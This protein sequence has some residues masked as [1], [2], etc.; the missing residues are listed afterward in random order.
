MLSRADARAGARILGAAC[1]NRW[2]FFQNKRK[3]HRDLKWDYIEV[4]KAKRESRKLDR[5]GISHTLRICNGRFGGGSYA[6][7]RLVVPLEFSL[8]EVRTPATMRKQ[9]KV[10]QRSLFNQRKRDLL[11]RAKG[12]RFGKLGHGSALHRALSALYEIEGKE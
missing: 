12:L 1:P 11:A 9:R 7:L 3:A 6:Q 8:T 5:A 4:K 10:S 2:S